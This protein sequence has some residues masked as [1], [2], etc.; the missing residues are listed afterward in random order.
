MGLY[1]PRNTLLRSLAAPPYAGTIAETGG[2]EL[3]FT[4]HD[5]SKAENDI[6]G[7]FR[8]RRVKNE[9]TFVLI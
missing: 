7:I 4:A 2:C 3:G 1:C 5:T 8:Y 9:L 6:F